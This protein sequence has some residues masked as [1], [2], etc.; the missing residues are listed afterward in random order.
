MAE[1]E[2]EQDGPRDFNQPEREQVQD[3]ITGEMVPADETIE[4][5]GYRVGAEGKQILMERLQS[6]QPVGGE[7]MR[8][9]FWRRLG[10]GVLDW[11]I[12]TVAGAVVGCASGA[13]FSSVANVQGGPFT[14]QTTP[15][16]N[17]IING[18]VSLAVTAG[19]IAYFA[20]QHGSSGQTVGK[21]A[22]DMVV[23]TQDLAEIDAR[24]AW[25]RGVYFLGPYLVPP[26]VYLLTPIAPGPIMVIGQ[27]LS[28]LALIYVLV[29]VIVGLADLD[30]QRA[31]HDRWAG[32][33]VIWRP[34]M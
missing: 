27:I 5:H 17:V 20:L 8:P 13:I 3:E 32:T 19:Y 25:L 34:A 28:V 33:R 9:G 6:G 21:R 4:L 18:F 26:L 10:C 24:T 29:D 31:L 7:S 1:H 16:F 14:A 22:G 12:V 11:I 2:S 23:V 15:W 30:Q